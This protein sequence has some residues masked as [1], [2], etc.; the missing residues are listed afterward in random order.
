MTSAVARCCHNAAAMLRVADM[1]PLKEDARLRAMDANEG[2]AKLLIQAAEIVDE[3]LEALR[4]ADASIRNHLRGDELA[5]AM[6]QKHAVAAIR[7][8][9]AKAEVRQP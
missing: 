4:I 3:M 7:A 8:A 5:S 9:I 2:Q 6:I 1:G